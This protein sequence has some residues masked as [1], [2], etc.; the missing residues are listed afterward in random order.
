MYI[1]ILF[2]C[3]VVFVAFSLLFIVLLFAVLLFLLVGYMVEVIPRRI[4]IFETYNCGA[5]VRIL[6]RPKEV[7]PCVRTCYMY[8]LSC[9]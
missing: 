1:C 7:K 2:C 3:F 4:E 9:R 5:I 6:A 8:R